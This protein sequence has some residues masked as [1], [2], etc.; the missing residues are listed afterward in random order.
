[1]RRRLGKAKIPG[2]SENHGP[3]F[4]N[5]DVL[6]ETPARRE[7]SS[8]ALFCDES[9]ERR[10]WNTIQDHGRAMEKLGVHDVRK[11]G[12]RELGSHNSEPDGRSI[13]GK[14]TIR[15]ARDG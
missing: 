12:T 6:R 1:M 13:S 5:I 10:R 11:N 3:E 14:E 9:G 15:E 7:Q 4:E 8:P 2:H